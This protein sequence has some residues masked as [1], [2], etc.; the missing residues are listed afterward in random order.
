[1]EAILPSR[2]QA[3]G[4]VVTVFLFW[5]FGAIAALGVFFSRPALLAVGVVIALP[6]GIRIYFLLFQLWEPA[7]GK[8]PWRM[9]LDQR[10]GRLPTDDW[11]HMRDLFRPSWIRHTLRETGWNVWLVGLGLAGLLVIDLGLFFGALFSGRHP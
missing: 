8:T 6:F 10:Q 3:R 4:L 9:L 7:T 1:M 2:S 5:A 11:Q